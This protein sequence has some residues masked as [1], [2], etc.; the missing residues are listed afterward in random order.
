MSQTREAAGEG[1]RIAASP[2]LSDASTATRRLP[3]GTSHSGMGAM[4][5]TIA[6]T[7][8]HANQLAPDDNDDEDD[9]DGCKFGQAGV[10]YGS[11]LQQE[12]I[13]RGRCSRLTVKHPII[14]LSAESNNF[15]GFLFGLRRR[16]SEIRARRTGTIPRGEL[17][18]P[19]PV[20]AARSS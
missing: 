19:P 15:P 5:K 11:R 8:Q 10:V 18:C 1:A 14:A 16:G 3:L 20:R 13:K 17:R 12:T 6:M 7:Q 9:E 2:W 4:F